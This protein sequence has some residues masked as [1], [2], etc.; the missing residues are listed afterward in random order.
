MY[1][2]PCE[3]LAQWTSSREIP[4]SGS[5]GG[6]LVVD[7]GS[8][9]GSDIVRGSVSRGPR[10]GYIGERVI[11]SREGQRSVWPSIEYTLF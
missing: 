8:L 11:G 9:S 1:Q 2:G 5:K 6:L 7:K 4:I 3:G 10:E